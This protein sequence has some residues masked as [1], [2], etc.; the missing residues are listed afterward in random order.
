MKKNGKTLY[1]VHGYGASPTNH[2]FPWLK[3]ELLTKGVKTNILA[4]PNSSSPV[5]DEWLSYLSKN[6]NSPTKATYFVA[7]SLG[8]ISLL[9]YL[10]KTELAEEIGGMIL[11]SGFTKPLPNLETIDEFTRKQL[12][13][14]KIIE[15]TGKRA[16][17]ASKDDSIVPF[18]FSKEL[19]EEVHADLYPIENGGHFLDREGFTTLPIIYDILSEMMGFA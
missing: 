8:C 14:S 12:D 17:V 5:L 7:H 11:V 9:K 3:K 13:Y 10:Q 16:V 2:W 4:M 15:I 1:I 19:A 6:I 18:L